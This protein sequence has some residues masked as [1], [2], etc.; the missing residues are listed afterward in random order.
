MYAMLRR[1]LHSSKFF[2]EN[3]TTRK[4]THKHTSN[5][6]IYQA[7]SEQVFFISYI[8]PCV[9]LRCIVRQDDDDASLCMCIILCKGFVMCVCACVFFPYVIWS[10]PTFSWKFLMVC[11][12]IHI[13]YWVWKKKPNTQI[14]WLEQW[15]F[16]SLWVLSSVV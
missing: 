13:T 14:L 4:H 11:T 1:S 3:D 12:Q 7:H 10:G 9:S 16:S 8:Y 6:Y 2:S 15:I 5:I